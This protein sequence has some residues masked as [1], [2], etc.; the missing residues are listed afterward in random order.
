LGYSKQLEKRIDDLVGDQGLAK[1]AMFG[2]IGYLRQGNM[3]FG[4]YKDDLIVRLGDPETV[5]GCL[6]REHVR[7]MD[8]TGRPMKG[9]VMV[10]P[11]GCRGPAALSEWLALGDR[12]ARR[13]PPK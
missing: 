11:D 13:L 9:W 3:C 2:G 6:A 12:C 10:A 1:K 4:I 8:I 5:A 7:P